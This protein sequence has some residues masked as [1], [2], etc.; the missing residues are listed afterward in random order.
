MDIT[1]RRR[2]QLKRLRDERFGGVTARM[3][4][5]LIKA[6]NYLSRILRGDKGI[7]ERFCRDIEAKLA[8]PNFWMDGLL[9]SEMPRDDIGQTVIDPKMMHRCMTVVASYLMAHPSRSVTDELRVEFACYLY[10]L[11]ADEGTTDEQ[12]SRHLG[13]YLNFALF[14]QKG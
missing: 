8:L 9:G 12:M 14:Q 3:A 11:F 6:P 4:E 1:E 2:S 5:A 7:A 13:K 10:S